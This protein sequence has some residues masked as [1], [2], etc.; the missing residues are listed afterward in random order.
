MTA[1]QNNLNLVE[2]LSRKSKDYRRQLLTALHKA[3]TGHP[4]GSLSAMDI[5]TA[6]YECVLRVDPARPD[7]DDRDRF[8]LSKG[9]TS[10]AL[11]VVLANKGFFPKSELDSLRKIGKLLQGSVDMKVPGVELSTGSLGQGLSIGVGMALGSKYLQKDFRVYVMLGDGESQEGQIW[12]AGMSGSHF[13]L[14]NLTAILDYN[15]L[16]GDGPVNATMNLEPVKA[17]WESFGWHV[18]EIDG[19]DFTQILSAF[20]TAKQ[21]KGKPTFIIA[22]TVKGK[23]VSYMENSQPW[24]GSK[25]PNSEELRQALLELA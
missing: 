1:A 16:Q 23:G 19:H 6:L 10:P 21:T 7:W 15:K 20:E 11:Y 3:G 17:R 9:Q 22:H 14:D 24:H 12:E 5:L 18:I 2:E 25:V 4:G 8:V 13:T